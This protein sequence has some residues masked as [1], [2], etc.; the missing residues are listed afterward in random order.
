LPIALPPTLVA[1]PPYVVVV[2]SSSSLLLLQAATKTVE[3]KKLPSTSG[4]V[5]RVIVML[6]FVVAPGAL[7]RIRQRV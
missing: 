6:L 3:T 2:S 4:K 7:R 1:A 5:L